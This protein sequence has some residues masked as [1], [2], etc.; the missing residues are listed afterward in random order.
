MIS[1]LQGSSDLK[2]VPTIMERLLRKSLTMI[3]KRIFEIRKEKKEFTLNVLFKILY[4]DLLN[5]SVTFKA[6]MKDCP[7]GYGW[8]VPVNI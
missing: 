1:F 3:L 7:N 4:N 5:N 8:N 6:Y 2:E